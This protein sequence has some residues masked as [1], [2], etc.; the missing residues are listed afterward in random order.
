[1][2][3]HVLVYLF[4]FLAFC[5][6]W[7]WL[8]FTFIVVVALII[9]HDASSPWH[10]QANLV[11][12]ICMCICLNIQRSFASLHKRMYCWIYFA[13]QRWAFK[14]YLICY[15]LLTV[16]ILY[17]NDLIFNLKIKKS[18]FIFSKEN[19]NNILKFVKKKKKENILTVI[20]S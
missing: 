11:C 7:S 17:Q 3:D 9:G 18:I 16:F 6:F 8:I 1:M 14:M 5:R 2:L 4:I 12:S 20:F 15:N 10:L 13:K 19:K